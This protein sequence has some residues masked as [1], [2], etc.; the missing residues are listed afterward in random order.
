MITKTQLFDFSSKYKI[1]ETT[2][3]REYIQLYLLSRLY[4]LNKAGIFFL[5]VEQRFILFINHPGFQKTLIL[6]LLIAK[7]VLH[8]L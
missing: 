3:L 2:I 1:N 5:K 7:K 8:S 6:P 4:S